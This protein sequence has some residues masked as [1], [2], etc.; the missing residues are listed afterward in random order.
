MHTSRPSIQP[1]PPP[2]VQMAPAPKPPRYYPPQ[3]HNDMSVIPNFQPRL[4]PRNPFTA[5][6]PLSAIPPHP[7]YTTDPSMQFPG[8]RMPVMSHIP[9]NMGLPPGSAGMMI[10]PLPRSIEHPAT[11]MR[12]PYVTPPQLMDPHRMLF[13]QPN[14]PHMP[15]NVTV[16]NITSHQR[17]SMFNNPAPRPAPP[18]SGTGMTIPLQVPI[19][20]PVN[21]PANTS[22]GFPMM[23]NET[24]ENVGMRLPIVIQ[25]E[26]PASQDIIHRQPMIHNTHMRLPTMISHERAVTSASDING[27]RPA[28]P[29]DV[30]PDISKIDLNL[31]KR[32]KPTHS[33]NIEIHHDDDVQHAVPMT[34]VNFICVQI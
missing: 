30:K 21:V 5:P 4:P 29:P 7:P 28:S 20:A 1:P 27:Y 15:P 23:Q 10:P 11:G 6:P 3:A 24:R 32:K 22:N 19:S 33:E 31:N 14:R 26:E 25:P 9:S 13:S 8:L 17:Y 2:L 12:L 34:Y 16:P 18:S